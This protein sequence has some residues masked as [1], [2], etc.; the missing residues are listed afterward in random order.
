[1]IRLVSLIIWLGPLAVVASDAV[2]G[3]ERRDGEFGLPKV[4][5]ARG[6]LIVQLGC[7]DGRT[8]VG[9]ARG[10]NFVV[11][12]LA[13]GESDVEPLRA[14]VASRGLEGRVSVAWIGAAKS[15]PYADNLVNWVVVPDDSVVSR[16]ESPLEE[17]IRILCP[18][19]V[20]TLDAKVARALADSPE[21]LVESIR[22]DPRVDYVQSVQSER[23]WLTFR[24]KRPQGMADWTHFR[25]GP[26]GNAV[27]PDALV[28]VPNSLRWVADSLAWP[29]KHFDHV[30]AAVSAG[31]RL[32]SVFDE[33][34]AGFRVS[35]RPFL[36]ARDAYNGILLWKRPVPAGLVSKEWN[37]TH[38]KVRRDAWL[39]NNLVAVG[40]HVFVPDI[41]KVL[42]L[43]AST[44]RIVR[45]YENIRPTQMAVKSGRLFL[46]GGDDKTPLQS[47]DAASGELGW[48]HTSA[49]EHFVCG[50][51][52]VFFVDSEGQTV[53]LD[54]GTGRLEW[55]QNYS[56]H[57][58]T[59]EIREARDLGHWRVVSC[60]DEILITS[61]GTPR[62]GNPCALRGISTDDGRHLWSFAYVDPPHNF[63]GSANN[64]FLSDGLVW[65]NRDA[66]SEIPNTTTWVGLNPS[67]GE[68]VKELPYGP[69]IHRC[70]PAQATDRFFFCGSF[71]VCDRRTGAFHR[72]RAAR[73]SC[74]LGVLPANGLVYTF[75][76]SCE[77][78][79][80]V[81]GFLAFA[82]CDSNLQPPGQ[83]AVNRQPLRQGPAFAWAAGMRTELDTTDQ[84][85]PPPQA[86]P[87]Y[88]HD[89]RR[90]GATGAFVPADLKELWEIR[91]ARADFDGPDSRSNTQAD[92]GVLSAPVTAAGMAFVAVRDR[93]QI[94]ALDAETGAECWRF[95]AGARVDSPPTIHRGLCLFGSHDGWV[96]CLRA[97]DGA[98]V[99]RFQG[100]PGDRLIMVDGQ[101]ESAWPTSGSVLVENETLYF[102]AGRHT[103]LDGGLVVYALDPWSGEVLWETRDA[104]P[105]QRNFDRCHVMRMEWV[106]KGTQAWWGGKRADGFRYG[107][108]YREPVSLG[109]PLASDG[110][111]VYLGPWP[112]G[113]SRQAVKPSEDNFVQTKA[114][115]FDPSWNFRNWWMDRRV[116]GHL[117]SFND[118]RTFAIRMKGFAHRWTYRA[119]LHEPG[120]RFE[121]LAQSKDIPNEFFQLRSV[122][123]VPADWV[124]DIPF[125][126]DAMVLT[127]TVLYVAGRP[128]AIGAEGGVLAA[129][130]VQTGEPLAEYQLDAPPV[131][132]GMAATADRLYLATRDGRLLCFSGKKR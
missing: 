86:W 46:T 96:Y 59:K 112:Y 11:H 53:C 78:D 121:L 68:I 32:F 100:A 9:H 48:K 73:N 83:S 8:M 104:R 71:D 45:T 41:G 80:Y 94:V 117:L 5:T 122:M 15:L 60:N 89:A 24:K 13:A 12:G 84:E 126:G 127:Q 79:P 69:A 109:G 75:P 39:V 101:L 129:Y 3:E 6:G 28:G 7:G 21:D 36:I 1:M 51:G 4:V 118:E 113:P 25:Y 82:S 40:E 115:F 18:D 20:A 19:G 52:R 123:Q 61:A 95:T 106:E 87:C 10:G 92:L 88:R 63:L 119:S 42:K 72:I 120:A 67:T 57:L 29:K 38:L 98:A 23:N 130:S 97:R 102:A 22:G 124:R 33:S 31:G 27:S 14:L 55:R 105:D 76:Q 58:L 62:K 16:L 37:H 49:V 47:L 35:R 30:F 54:A 131:F 44:G 111:S 110:A 34:P 107:V 74:G 65:V 43:D 56:D 125:V 116:G 108:S 114:G 2:G 81:R 70:R 103:D 128:D 91:I 64:A 50:E 26:E 85:K 77:C 99:W 90:S 17:L 93:H 132:D 66:G